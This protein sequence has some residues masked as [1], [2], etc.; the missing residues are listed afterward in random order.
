[1][2]V[3]V[4]SEQFQAFIQLLIN[5]L[6]HSSSMKVIV[7]MADRDGLDANDNDKRRWYTRGKCTLTMILHVLPV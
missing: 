2:N 5:A 3:Q 7:T 4:G 6:G 1:L